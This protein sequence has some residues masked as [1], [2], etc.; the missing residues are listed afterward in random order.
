MLFL[1]DQWYVPDT[2]SPSNFDTSIIGDL[3]NTDVGWPV[4]A[5]GES[6]QFKH[7]EQRNEEILQT[8]R[9]YSTGTCYNERYVVSDED[10]L[11][12]RVKTATGKEVR[13]RDYDVV[14]ISHF[15]M[16]HFYLRYLLEEFPEIS[17]VGIQEEAVQD[18]AQ[19]SSSLQAAHFDTVERLD[20]YVAFNEQ[21][22]QWI[23]PHRPNVIQMTLPVPKDQFPH[24]PLPRDE[25]RNAA[26][27][28]IATW[29]IDLANFYSNIRVL[30]RVRQN[31]APHSGEII[32]IR[33]RQRSDTNGLEDRFDFL[34][35]DGFVETGIYERIANFDFAIIMSMRATAGRSAADLAGMG[36]PC[37]G[38]IHNNFQA[39]CFPDL[40]VEPHDV[41]T[42][43]ALAE[44]LL[45]DDTFYRETIERA[46]REIVDCQNHDH[47]RGR[48]ERY[49]DSVA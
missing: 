19:T 18:L 5:D 6:V 33:D 13:V 4:T 49:I 47:F 21:F 40:S 36:V 14:L 11:C 34:Q 15:W 27:L 46:R 26:C 22:R 38:N 28:G 17:F 1:E 24:E 8:S 48:L 7:A 23:S 31:G 20:G 35:V 44:R 45:N 29:N 42:A 32:G 30:D 9:P 10:E 2:D 41:Q 37:I 3:L 39:R 25:R 12:D 43:T 16:H